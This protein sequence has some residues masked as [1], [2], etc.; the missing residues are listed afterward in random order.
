MSNAMALRPRAEM[1]EPL[2][3]NNKPLNPD[4]K[5]HAF[6]LGGLNTL[7][8]LVH[9]ASFVAALI[10]S[11]IYRDNSVL[12]EITTQFRVYDF[13]AT[14]PV[15]GIGGALTSELKSLGTFPLIWVDLPFPFITAFFHLIIARSPIIRTA[16]EHWVFHEGRNPLRWLEYGITAS[17]MT[18][19]IAQLCG[20]TDI[21]LVILVG[22][23]FNVIVQW[24]GHLMEVVNIPFTSAEKPKS[25]GLKPPQGTPSIRWGPLVLGW[26]AFAA[27]WG[28]MLV[29]FFTAV[30][31][32]RPAA[33][34]EVPMFVYTIVLG[35]LGQ[36]AIFG[37]VLTNRY[38]GWV[39]FLATSFGVE[40][41]YI[42]LSLTS[43]LWLTW[44]LLIGIVT[45]AT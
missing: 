15:N 30:E 18:F 24:S 13:N 28:P 6:V 25:S 16:Y 31:S 19:V 21:F 17:L 37:L 35:L 43:K 1:K 42:L 23:V 33:T 29:Y 34:Q 11:I 9:A 4:Q 38:L 10:I 5:Q 39:G 32:P 3:E 2:L 41:S 40:V 44:N 8:A 22:F 7:A 14:T 36:F 45:N 27:Q 12:G 26:C 20:I